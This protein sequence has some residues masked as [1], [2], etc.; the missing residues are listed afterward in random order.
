M[1]V[2]SSPRVT[3]RATRRARDLAAAI[4]QTIQILRKAID[5]Y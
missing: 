2:T 3:G 1:H 5:Q 4:G